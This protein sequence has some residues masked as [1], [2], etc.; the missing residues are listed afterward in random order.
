M[1]IST[2][3][4]AVALFTTAA[5]AQDVTV[6]RDGD[7]LTITRPDGTV[8]RFTIDEDAELRVRSKDGPLVIEREDGDEAGPRS[9]A[10]RLRPGEAPFR[11]EDFG[12]GDFDLEEFDFEID[13]D[14]LRERA[15]RFRLDAERLGGGRML[16]WAGSAHRGVD[17]ETRS[18][19]AAGERRSRTLARQLRRAEEAER[20]RLARELRETLE[21]TF[22]LKQ[23]ARRQQVE[24][25]REDAERL[26]GE[27]AE[28][29]A[30]RSER[31]AAR[32]EIIER[33][34]QE[35]LGERDALDW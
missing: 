33:R 9:F 4:L 35:L 20:D 23:Q 5:A 22:D 16:P 25:M 1:R 19:I 12:L 17:P 15:L 28:L 3:C 26:R 8:E 32:D 11:S 14:S 29:E 21:R 34:R 30:E 7:E 10:F 2:L 13:T 27:L 31:D 24:A 6:E 18:E